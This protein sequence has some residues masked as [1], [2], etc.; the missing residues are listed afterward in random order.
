MEVHLQGNLY[1]EELR[2]GWG[3]GASP[4]GDGLLTGSR[5]RQDWGIFPEW[6]NLQD[7]VLVLGYRVEGT[8]GPGA[9]GRERQPG[10]HW[11]PDLKAKE[12]RENISVG[13]GALAGS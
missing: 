11:A 6:Q 7:R 2:E 12:P 13:R 8:A 1:V 5:R 3:L 10:V 9:W 4:R